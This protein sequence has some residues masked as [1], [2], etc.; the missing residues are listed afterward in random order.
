MFERLLKIFP[1]IIGLVIIV[2]LL[3][4]DFVWLKKPQ[5]ENTQ[6]PIVQPE[7][8]SNSTDC[9]AC[10]KIIT[11]EIAR[12]VAKIT[13]VIEKQ[14]IQP[15]VSPKSVALPTSTPAVKI[16]YQSIGTSGTTTNTNWT[17]VPGTDFYFNLTDYPGLINVRWETSLQAFITSTDVFAR[18]Y[19]VTNKRGV[20]YS[21]LKTQST[22]YELLRSS[23]LVIWR[24]NNLYR[25]QIK[26]LNGNTVNILTPK[27]KLIY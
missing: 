20:D 14:V 15:T 17:D 18:L 9:S 2:N 21:E 3:I 23:D 12:E 8:I 22:T 13:P 1:W 19:D 10:Q 16:T 11:D 4:L 25:I 26:G 6:A 7:T 27:L 5:S 24:G